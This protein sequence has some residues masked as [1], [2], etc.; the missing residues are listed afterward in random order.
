M[1]C[2]QITNEGQIIIDPF[3]GAGSTGVGVM[4]NKCCFIGVE[5]DTKTFFGAVHNVCRA[6]VDNIGDWDT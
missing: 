3:M 5:K 2:K 6:M 1:N 4:R